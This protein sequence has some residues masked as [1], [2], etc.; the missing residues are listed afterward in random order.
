MCVCVCVFI[1]FAHSQR[2]VITERTAQSNNNALRVVFAMSVYIA[3]GHVLNFRL[4]VCFFPLY[5]YTKVF[6]KLEV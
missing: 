4:I 6:A 1:S 5:N 3:Q 2:F